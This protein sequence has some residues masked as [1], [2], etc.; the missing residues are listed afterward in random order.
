MIYR[1]GPP[2]KTSSKSHPLRSYGQMLKKGLCTGG[3]NAWPVGEGVVPVQIVT[4]PTVC[5]QR[6]FIINHFLSDKPLLH[7]R[8]FGIESRN[9]LKQRVLL[10]NNHP[11]TPLNTYI[12]LSNKV[13]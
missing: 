8:I 12:T 3:S 1:R 9:L 5:W 10:T 13:V 11:D 4:G 2:I 7:Y 6:Y